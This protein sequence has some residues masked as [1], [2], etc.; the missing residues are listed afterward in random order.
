MRYFAGFN[1]SLEET[2]IC[3]IDEGGPHLAGA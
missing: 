1:V 2:A 3:I